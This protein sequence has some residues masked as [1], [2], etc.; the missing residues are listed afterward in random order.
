MTFKKE[1]TIFDIDG[2]LFNSKNL[3]LESVFKTIEDFER[4]FT[5]KM[6][7]L[8]DRDKILSG[9][10]LSNEKFIDNLD[11]GLYGEEKDYFR[12]KLIYNEIKLMEKGKGELFIGIKDLLD[13]LYRNKIKMAIGSGCRREYLISFIETFNLESYFE[14]SICSD[15]VINGSKKDIIQTI[16][17]HQEVLASESLYI[18]DTYTD[19]LGALDAGVDFVG[20]L[21]G[22]GKKED[23][24]EDVK[25][26][27][28]PVELRT[29]IYKLIDNDYF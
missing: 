22:Y 27:S 3:V 16:L 4:E 2:V 7:K 23:F 18:G 1:L 19:Y 17:E 8:P 14:I 20:V 29:Y 15:D 6:L 11:F 21:W 10:G 13:E 24:S 9:V 26:V 5:N 28:S 12:S 25:L